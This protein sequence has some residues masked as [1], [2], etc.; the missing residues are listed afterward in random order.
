MG[1]F[2]EPHGGTLKDCYLNEAAAEEEKVRAGNYPVWS[3]T[4]RQLCDLDMLTNGAFSPLEGFNTQ[5]QYEGICR[6]MRLPDGV[7]WPVPVCLD[8]SEAFSKE[9]IIGNRIALRDPEGVLLATM[10]VEDIYTP[11]KKMEAERI[12]ATQDESH[13]GVN[14]L[15]NTAG[16]VYELSLIHI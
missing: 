15:V 4:A 8:V 9:L 7:L 3:L 14:Y 11:D 1:A 5:A 16:P 2:K 10:D 13:P 12:Y 6:D